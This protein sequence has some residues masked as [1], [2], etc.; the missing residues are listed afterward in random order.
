MEELMMAK[1]PCIPAPSLFSSISTV[2]TSEQ[3]REQNGERR[4]TRAR[5]EES[6]RLEWKKRA[7]RTEREQ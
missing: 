4:G 1:I 7:I 6:N 3:H 2:L 5:D